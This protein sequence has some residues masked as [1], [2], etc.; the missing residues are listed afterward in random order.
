MWWRN[1]DMRCRTDRA[2]TTGAWLEALIF[3]GCLLVLLLAPPAWAAAEIDD[4]LEPRSREWQDIRL[5]HS[6][7][8]R[9]VEVGD[10]AY[11]GQTRMSGKWGLGIVVDR[12]H[13]A[14]GATNH[15]V[16]LLKRF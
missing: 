15:G 1:V 4:T 12:G 14:Y 11:V 5:D 2:K 9:G 8:V 13:Y 3:S 16:L 10:R 6:L 7:R